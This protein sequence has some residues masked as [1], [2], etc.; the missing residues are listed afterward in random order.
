MNQEITIDPEFRELCP[1]LS[2]EERDG[3]LESLQR[4]GLISPLVVWKHQGATIL[5]GGHN[6]YEIIT[7]DLEGKDLE[8]EDIKITTKEMYFGSRDIAKNWIIKNQLARRNLS[9]DAASLLRG[10]LYN[11][12]KQ[13]RGG[14][15]KSEE[16]KGSK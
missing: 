3:L 4:D 6:R 10:K 14:D 2:S 16:S 1:P 11:S 13:S 15:R 5:I 7:Q 12:R 9:P 8:N